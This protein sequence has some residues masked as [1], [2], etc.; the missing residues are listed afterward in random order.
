MEEELRQAQKMEAIGQLTGG[1]AHDFNNLLTVITGNLEMLE[2]SFKD[3]AQR[4][5]LK[6]AQDAAED[7][8]KL[9]GQLLAF[10]RRQPLNPK[11]TD[12]TL[13]DIE[14]LRS[15]APKFGRVN[16]IEHPADRVE[17]SM[18]R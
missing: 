7:G 11:P 1:L 16:R 15:S 3:P 4:G 17:A 14:F 5:L 9:T 8:A 6:D 2:M 12:L 13:V 10:G 18:C